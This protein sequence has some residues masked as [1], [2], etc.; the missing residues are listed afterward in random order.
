MRWL[1]PVWT[2]VWKLL[3]FLSLWG[4]ML[5]LFI[6]PFADHI[7]HFQKACPSLARLYFDAATALTVLAAAWIMARLIDRRRFMTLGFAPK[8]MVRDLLLGVG[9]GAV[10]LAISVLALWMVDCVFLRPSSAFSSS[11]LAWAGVALVFNTIAQEVLVRSYVF[12]TIQSQTNSI[13]AIVLTSVLFMALHAGAYA[14]AWLPA[15]NVFLAGVLFGVAYYLTGN[16]WLPIAIHYAWNMLLGPALG[17]TVSGRNQLNSGWR[18]L[19]VQG[20]AW[21]TGGAFG[22]EGGLIV[23][24]TTAMVAVVMIFLF[25]YGKANWKIK[26]PAVS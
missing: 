3:L 12:Q 4:L 18:L 16:L 19:T 22:V 17:L 14:G 5:A 26:E 2:I 20:P 21:L 6:I 8:N 13:W 11:V 25:R 23:T 9:V 7:D 15:I 1:L 10:W 24:L